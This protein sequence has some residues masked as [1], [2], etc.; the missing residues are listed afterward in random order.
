ML[1]PISLSIKSLVISCAD[2]LKWVTLQSHCD[3]HL[4][5][6]GPLRPVQQPLLDWPFRARSNNYNDQAATAEAFTIFSIVT[7]AL[8][9]VWFRISLTI[10]RYAFEWIQW[11]QEV[12]QTEFCFLLREEWYLFSPCFY[13]TFFFLL[14]QGTRSIKGKSSEISGDSKSY[15][16]GLKPYYFPNK[17]A[18]Q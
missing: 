13:V 10:S 16:I 18:F 12:A 4:P 3:G 11:I 17:D 15:L 6:A 7:G 1:S 2:M 8:C 5:H 9:S 14:L